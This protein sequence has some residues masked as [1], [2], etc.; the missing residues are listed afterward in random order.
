MAFFDFL[1]KG[2]GDNR[3]EVTAR[4]SSKTS[5]NKISQ[6]YTTEISDFPLGEEKFRELLLFSEEKELRP[7]IPTLKGCRALEISP[8]QSSLTSLLQL[9][10]PSLIA[11]VGGKREKEMAMVPDAH[12]VLSHWESLPFVE[13]SWDFIL[14]RNQFSKLSL[15]RVL[16]E[17][18]R[19]LKPGG[20]ILLSDFHP[21]SEMVQKEHMK[22]PVGEDALNPG[23]EKY[24]KFFK[25]SDLN[26]DSVKEFFFD[27]SLRKYFEGSSS[28]KEMFESLRKTPFLIFF[29][30]Q[31]E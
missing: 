26:L 8:R 12:F 27:G 6:G 29:L 9:M 28:H 17:A 16:R 30:L 18:S 1:K 25:E 22:S 11:R 10:S 15:S 5:T 20:M 21:F 4:I 7:R 13:G 3:P 31:K 14:L 24:F 2:K 19:V 23:F